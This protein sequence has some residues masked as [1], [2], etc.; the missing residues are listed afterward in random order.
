[1]FSFFY[2]T[3]K[4]FYLIFE[5]YE[6][7]S[8]TST[9]SSS[10]SNSSS[11]SSSSSHK[12]SSSSSSSATSH[13]A[14]EQVFNTPFQSIVD[15]FIMTMGDTG[16]IYEKLV[17]VPHYVLLGQVCEHSFLKRAFNNQLICLS[18]IK[19][20]SLCFYSTPYCPT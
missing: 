15:A 9:S 16:S 2:P 10:G 13:H 12:S 17:G 3:I 1:M 11:S 4:A 7:H 20:L 18:F 19:N 6:T 5:A 14:E 8:T